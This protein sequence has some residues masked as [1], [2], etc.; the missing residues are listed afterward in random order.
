LPR[1]VEYQLQIQ[2]IVGPCSTGWT[3]VARR[4]LASTCLTRLSIRTVIARSTRCRP[5]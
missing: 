1:W 4:T 2:H 5:S 3:I